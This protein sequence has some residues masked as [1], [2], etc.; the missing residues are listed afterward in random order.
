MAG[1]AGE[2]TLD[3]GATPSTS[4]SVV[5]TGLTGITGT[6]KVEAWLEP[7]DMTGVGGATEDAHFAALGVLIPTIK[8]STINFGGADRM[9]IEAQLDARNPFT[10]KWNVGY[11]W[12]G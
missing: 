7:A 10:G 11:A 4:A 3:F 5:V 9:T 6:A 8:K 12:N 2:A 1:G